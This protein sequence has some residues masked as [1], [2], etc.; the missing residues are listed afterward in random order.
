MIAK[1]ALTFFG[2]TIRARGME[3]DIILGTVEGTRRRGS[4]RTRW[5]DVLKE[6]TG[7]SLHQL[8]ET[9]M[10]RSEWRSFVQRIA[11]SRKRLDGT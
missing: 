5:L 4:H 11:R 3:K 8:N 10:N 6:F 9:A 1:Q 2:H 7:M